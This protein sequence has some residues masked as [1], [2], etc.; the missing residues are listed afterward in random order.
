MRL[1]GYLKTNEWHEWMSLPHG[2]W[3]EEELNM[4]L[5]TVNIYSKERHDI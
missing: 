4:W 1:R 2:F 3:D 5:E